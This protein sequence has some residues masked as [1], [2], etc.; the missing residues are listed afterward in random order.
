MNEEQK[1]L[2]EDR[3][4]KAHWR[5]W[6]PYLS[7]RQWGTVREDY[8]ADGDAWSYFPFDQAAARAYRWGEDGI[9]GISD[10]H[11]RLCLSFA[12]WNEKDPFLKERLFGLNNQEG[13][14]GEDVKEI[15]YYL[16]ST[17]THSYMKGL[18]KYPQEAFPYDLLKRENRKRTLKQDEFEL[19]DTGVFDKDRYYDIFAEYAKN[20]FEELAVRLTIVNR[21][22][23]KTRLHVLPHLWLRNTWVW[24]KQEPPA[25]IVLRNQALYVDLPDLGPRF[26]Y[27]DG[28]PEPLFTN[29]ETNFQKLFNSPNRSPFVK[30]AFHEALIHQNRSLVNPDK[31]GT[32]AALHYILEFAPGETKTLLFSLSDQVRKEPFGSFDTLFLKRK[33]EAD[34]FY[35]EIL[36]QGLSFELQSIQRQAFAGLLWS[37]QFYHYVVEEW[38]NGDDPDSPPPASHKKIRNFRWRHLYNEDVLSMPDKWE[39]PWFAQWDLGFHCV[40][41]SIIDPEFAKRQLSLLTREWYMHPNGQIPAYEWDF[42]DVNP[43]I[44]A[45]AVWRVYKIEQRK[46]GREDRAFLEQ[47]FQK[48]LLF[49]TWWVNRKDSQD[50]NV[51]EG[52]FLGLDNISVFNRSAKLPPGATLVQSDATSWMGMFCLSMWTIAIELAVKEPTYEDMA[53][54]FY[55]HFLYIADAINYE[56]PGVPPL[57]D[58]EDGFYYDLLQHPNGTFQSLKI[59]SLVGLIPLF[60]VATLAE[61]KLDQLPAFKKRFHWFLDN[62]QDLSAHVASL[63]IKN[64][65]NQRI[66]AILKQEQLQRVLETMLDENEFLS[67]YGIRSVS[68]YHRDHPFIFACNGM[69]HQVGYEPAESTSRLF[70]GNSN[71]R[72]PVWIPI[73]FL[74]IESLQKFHYYFGDSFKV[75]CPRGSGRWLNLAQVAE[76]LS[77]RL[78]SLFESNADGNRPVFGTN[79]KFQTD[80]HFKDYFLFYEYFHGDDGSGLGASHQTGWSALIAKLIQQHYSL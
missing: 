33:S 6:G 74:I 68:K 15:Y 32:K 23:Q 22:D 5:R 43:P 49:F 25:Q 24:K 77:K 44:Y 46:H 2:V 26:F 34:Q 55:E 69:R 17:P 3:D 57:W 35:Q 51:F 40:T 53:S 42:E 11:Q 54:K 80:P 72:G 73:N 14:H 41:L 12:F 8:S 79:R 29:N 56:H 31:K 67:P 58:D 4:K 36:P 64:E 37:K 75:E 60:A 16:D 21:G 48:L 9:L 39:Y 50:K 10:N 70:G 27:F 62:R 47:M 71:W 52:G 18:Y 61:E 1:R 76:E 30:D 66:L 45:W 7:E 63:R 78:I 65:K 13:N 38:L 59:R 20:T 19:I 28:H